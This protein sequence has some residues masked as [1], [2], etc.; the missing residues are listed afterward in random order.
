MNHEGN[1][2]LRFSREEE[3]NIPS[4]K[5]GQMYSALSTEGS[6]DDE[7]AVFF[8]S[9]SALVLSRMCHFSTTEHSEEQRHSLADVTDMMQHSD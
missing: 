4:V 2:F 7:V 9:F 8:F 3:R 6:K 5:K 1:S